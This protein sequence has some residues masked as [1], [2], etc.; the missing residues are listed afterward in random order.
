VALALCVCAAAAALPAQ[1]A[2]KKAR[3]LIVRPAPD[4]LSAGPKLRIVV[5]GRKRPAVKLNRKSIT[6][7]FKRGRRNTWVARLKHG[8][9]L[10]YGVN[11][12]VVATKHY[13]DAVRFVFARRA[14][15]QLTVPGPNRRRSLSALRTSARTK[16]A[17]A[18]RAR[19]NGHAVH[20]LFG[21]HRGL[22]RAT[23]SASDGLH[24]GRNRLVV[25]SFSDGGRWDREVSTITVPR[26]HPLVGAGKNRSGHRGRSLRLNGRSSRASSRKRKLRY[27]WKIV[28]RPTGAKAKL[29]R[30]HSARPSLKPDRNGTWRVRLTVS[31]RHGRRLR[32][33][34]DVVRLTVRPDV[35]PVGAALDTR[36]DDGIALTLN[37]K[38]HV[39]A[40]SDV[41]PLSV[42]VLDRQTLEVKK[43]LSL[44]SSKPAI[45]QLAGVVNGLD[46]TSIV[47][48]SG[49]YEDEFLPDLPDLDAVAEQIGVNKDTL[50]KMTFEGGFSFVGVKGWKQ[51]T[52]WVNPGVTLH[53]DDSEGDLS[54]YL[55]LDPRLGTYGMVVGDFVDFETNA[56]GAAA[57]TNRMRI[58]SKTYDSSV[59]PAGYA[60]FH[61]VVTD[62]RTLALKRNL[63]YFTNTGA[64][65]ADQA[66]QR[67]VA[68]ALKGAQ[69]DE[70]V[71]MQSFGS[72]RPSGLSDWTGIGE[73]VERIGGTRTVVNQLDGA[74]EY[75]LVGRP[76]MSQP[77][78]ESTHDP[79]KDS[80]LPDGYRT[81]MAGKL[82]GMLSRSR[83][84]AYEPASE[85]PSGAVLTN[86]LS[87]I[88]Y[89]APTPFPAS[90]TPGFT[91][92]SAYIAD[93]L[94][95]R[96]KTDVRRNY[97]DD[98]V[99]WLTQKDALDKL[100]YPGGSPGFSQ[101]EFSTLKAQ[102]L[103]E[104]P[105]VDE[106]KSKLIPLLQEPFKRSV[107]TNYAEVQSIQDE[108]FQHSGKDLNADSVTSSQ[109]IGLLRTAVETI[110]PK[111]S[112]DEA[113][114]AAV[115]DPMLTVLAVAGAAASYYESQKDDG[116][117]LV[118]A[119][120]VRAGDLA[121]ETT[122][123]FNATLT[124]LDLAGDI[125]VTDYGKLTTAY[126]KALGDPHWTINTQQRAKAELRLERSAR[127][128]LYGELIRVG[129]RTVSLP[130]VQTTQACYFLKWH[131]DRF[132]QQEPVSAQMAL[133]QGYNG[134]SPQYETWGLAAGDFSGKIDGLHAPGPGLTDHLFRPITLDDENALGLYKPWFF[135]RYL[136]ANQTVSPCDTSP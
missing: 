127:E 97:T 86:D 10:R 28:T 87:H 58:G 132:G 60:G 62:A 20:R 130:G 113:E 125:L 71:F 50:S 136:P 1:A 49:D 57:R 65:S 27:R 107:L 112:V 43:E 54:G 101:A 44:S 96:D 31:E 119:F 69:D 106:I 131:D 99:N 35:P 85:D 18:F 14:R 30:P 40:Q 70:L 61:I 128:W 9:K 83:D 102:L 56:D 134:A 55:Q 8:S 36:A 38:R 121:H 37:G 124:R 91:K 46:N 52:A 105:K 73:G 24:F 94:G 23:L 117:S 21:L 13:V 5:R 75:A 15:S 108:A 115:M 80:K 64:Q 16:P 76:G 89:Q 48:I 74:G 22:R 41:L 25:T 26:T 95:L 2:T 79:P 118:D 93:K 114:A 66:G 81:G 11:Y 33:T 122:K 100:D 92:A 116:S 120:R 109:L 19:L 78:A 82:T 12:L 59:F 72:P 104:F 103:T 129:F 84:A 111:I 126:Q 98:L 4:G 110:V 45:D 90:G 42:L 133:V 32:S 63:T 3:D 67:A 34:S 47:I 17:T 39:Y 51:G 7:S 88:L 123:R 6:R 29:H 135:K 68:A 53:P 77:A